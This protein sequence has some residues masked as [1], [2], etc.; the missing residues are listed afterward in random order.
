MIINTK[1]NFFQSLENILVIIGLISIFISIAKIIVFIY[2]KSQ[3]SNI[4]VVEIQRSDIEVESYYDHPVKDYYKCSNDNYIVLLGAV[5]APFLKFKM[6]N[7]EYKEPLAIRI[8]EKVIPEKYRGEPSKVVSILS[9]ISKVRFKKTRIKKKFQD[10]LPGEYF[11]VQVYPSETMPFIRARFRV[12]GKIIEYDFTG[13]YL[14]GNLQVKYL[15]EKRDL[16]S[17]LYHYFKIQ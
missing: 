13:D 9:R 2:D 5:D 1:L 11:A 6:Y 16:M 7:L 17:F 3:Y 12:K 14:H 10:I 4:E 8:Y 15:K